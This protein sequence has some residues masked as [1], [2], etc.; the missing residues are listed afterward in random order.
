LYR[1]NGSNVISEYEQRVPTGRTA[2]EF[3]PTS[4]TSCIVPLFF[5]DTLSLELAL[6]AQKEHI[7]MIRKRSDRPGAQGEFRHALLS[8][9]LWAMFA[10]GLAIE[11]LAPGLKIENHAFVMPPSALQ[12]GTQICP[13]ALVDHE[14]RMQSA[15]A[16]LTIGSAVALAFWKRRTLAEALLPRRSLSPQVR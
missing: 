8:V 3:R 11:A 13:D 15:A 5:P 10:S 7:Q 14:R 1:E 2:S 4:A 12:Q 9:F 6:S 16:T